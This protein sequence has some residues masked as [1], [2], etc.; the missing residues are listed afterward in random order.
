MLADTALFF[1]LWLRK[2]LQ[3]AAICP[4]GS[5]VAAAMARLVDWSRPGPVLELGAGTGS[6]TRG[7][8]EA[9]WPPARIIACEREARFADILRRELDGVRVVV[10][11]AADLERQLTRLG[12]DQ[13]SAVV[14]SLPIK[15]FPRDAQHAVLRAS[16]ARLGCGGCFLQLTNAFSSPLPIE[17]LGVDGREASRV[18]RNLPPAQ[19]WAYTA[20]NGDP[21][22]RML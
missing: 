3:I 19:I 18:W 16:F 2:P 21:R 20:R 15:W 13:L 11:D 6:I 1:G 10:G 14:S 4:S 5:A 17:P 7:L 22:Q 12:I 8:L 9:G